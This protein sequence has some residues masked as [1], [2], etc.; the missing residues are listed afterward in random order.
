[1]YTSLPA[2]FIVLRPSSVESQLRHLLVA[3]W[4]AMTRCMVCGWLQHG[5]MS[6]RRVQH[7]LTEQTCQMAI[8]TT[9]ETDNRVRGQDGVKDFDLACNM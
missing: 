7:V 6:T 1:M 4:A 8:K 5:K 2:D 3:S 9:R